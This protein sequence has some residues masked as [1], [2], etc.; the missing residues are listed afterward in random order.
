MRMMMVVGAVANGPGCRAVM[1]S[2]EVMWRAG[3]Y[4]RSPLRSLTGLFV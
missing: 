3:G 2:T 4:G 1:L